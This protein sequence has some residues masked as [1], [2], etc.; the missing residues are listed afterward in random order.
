MLSTGSD[1]CKTIVRLWKTGSNYE[2]CQ[3]LK[4]TALSV[5]TL[6]VGFKVTV[7]GTRAAFKPIRLKV[8]LK[9]LKSC[10]PDAIPSCHIPKPVVKFW[11]ACTKMLTDLLSLLKDK[12][13]L[14]YSVMVGYLQAI[15][16]AIEFCIL[17]QWI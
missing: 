5:M 11:I 17:Q 2:I 4:T 6:D 7:E 3:L 9:Y 15:S 16:D 14:G 8:V 10:F 13:N 12:W 1:T